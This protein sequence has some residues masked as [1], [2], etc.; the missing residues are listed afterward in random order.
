MFYQVLYKYCC[1]VF[2]F[3]SSRRRHTRCSRDWSSD[4]CSSD[5]GE[6]RPLTPGRGGGIRLAALRDLRGRGDDDL[7]GGPD[8]EPD[9][10]PREAADDAADEDRPAVRGLE[11]S[12]EAE[13]ADPVEDV[14]PTRDEGEHRA[15]PEPPEGAADE[16]A[17]DHAR[18]NRGVRRRKERSLDEVEVVQHTD[19]GDAG[20]E[21]KPAQQKQPTLTAEE[22]H[23]TAS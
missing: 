1:C 13:L 5:L 15:P 2:F 7:L 17:G 18:A 11:E 20:E 16:A 14:E 21:M 8:D 12:E 19:P 6:A 3:F 22:R 9:V 23:F 10:E 4:V